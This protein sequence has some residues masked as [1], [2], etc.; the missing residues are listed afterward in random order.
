MP[1]QSCVNM[2]H[3]NTNSLRGADTYLG[4]E[5]LPKC[6]ADFEDRYV[7]LSMTHRGS[8]EHHYGVSVPVRNRNRLLSRVRPKLSYV[9]R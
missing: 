4:R 3:L 9:S 6:D 1:N 5:I 8:R 2:K 7:D